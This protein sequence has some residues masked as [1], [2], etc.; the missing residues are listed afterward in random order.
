MFKPE[1][2]WSCIAHKSSHCSIRYHPC[3]RIRNK[4][5]PVIKF[6]KVNPGSSF[7]KSP[8]AWVYNHFVQ[9]W[10]HFKAFIIPIILY[11]FKKDPICLIILEHIL[12]YFIH[13][14]KAPGQEE[15]T[16][17][18]RSYTLITGCMFKKIALPSDFMH[19]FQG[20]VMHW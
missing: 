9:F 13:V 8:S 15:T 16:L 14:Y 10:Q 2:H 11:Q 5:D 12:F 20:G 7:E 18:D 3:R 1:D 17:G 6:V 4:F 19:I